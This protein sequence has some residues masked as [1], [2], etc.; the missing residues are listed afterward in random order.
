MLFN[1]LFASGWVGASDGALFTS[2]DG[3]SWEPVATPPG[4]GIT[5]LTEWDGNLVIVGE[6]DGAIWA[7]WSDASEWLIASLDDPA[8]FRDVVPFSSRVLVVGASYGE[9][10]DEFQAGIWIGTW[11]R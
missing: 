11:D 8:G 2:T 4:V 10:F 9:D 5:R 6:S 3:L 7:T 1:P